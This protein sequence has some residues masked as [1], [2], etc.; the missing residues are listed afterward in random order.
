MKTSILV[1]GIAVV[2]LSVVIF[3]AFALPAMFPSQPWVGRIM[4]SNG[5][6]YSCSTRGRGIIGSMMD[7]YGMGSSMMNG[8]QEPEYAQYQQHINQMMQGRC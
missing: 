1:A 6:N 7:G 3:Q 4:P 2:V 8:G 5:V